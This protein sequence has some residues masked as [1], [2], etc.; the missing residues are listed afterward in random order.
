MSCFPK[1]PGAESTVDLKKF[2][3]VCFAAAFANRTKEPLPPPNMAKSKRIPPVQPSYLRPSR[4]AAKRNEEKMAQRQAEQDQRSKDIEREFTRE[5]NAKAKEKQVEAGK[6]FQARLQLNLTR[7]EEQ[8]AK[9][10]EAQRVAESS[11]FISPVKAAPARTVTIPINALAINVESDEEPEPQNQLPTKGPPMERWSPIKRTTQAPGGPRAPPQEASPSSRA[12][13]WLDRRIVKSQLADYEPPPPIPDAEKPELAPRMKRYGGGESFSYNTSGGIIPKMAAKRCYRVLTYTDTADGQRHVMD[14]AEGNE[15]WCRTGPQKRRITPDAVAMD[16]KQAALSE[17]F[18]LTQV[19]AATSGNG[20]L[21]RMLVAFDCWG[22]CSRR[23]GGVEAAKYEFVKYIR[24]ED[25]LNA[26]KTVSKK[27]SERP[28]QPNMFAR[29]D[30]SPLLSTRKSIDRSIYLDK[31]FN[32]KPWK[33]AVGG[34]VSARTNDLMS[35]MN[36]VKPG[37]P[38]TPV[39]LDATPDARK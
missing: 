23:N 28:T 35:S 38:A 5:K 33:R 25:F 21:P 7:Y 15:Y 3:K 2:N 20:T 32:T 30:Q 39:R 12:D 9:L 17:R 13:M 1:N 18:P 6:Q 24:I 16:S 26:P 10:T 34:P 29:Q 4:A 31:N 19:G 11:G 37:I 8:A 36:H 22:R 27:Q 14:V